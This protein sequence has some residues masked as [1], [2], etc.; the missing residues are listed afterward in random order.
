[1]HS[2]PTGWRE[3]VGQIV[4][5][6]DAMSGTLATVSSE[7]IASLLRDGSLAVT[8]GQLVVQIRCRLPEVA[9][10][11]H[12]AYAF[13]PYC[14]EPEFADFHVELRVPRNLRRWYRPQV[15]FLVDG[16]SPFQPLP[17]D[18]APALLEWG[19]NWS[20][21]ASCHQWLMIHAASLER[22]GR[23]VIL[24]APPGSGKSTLAAALALRGWRL[25]SDE[26]T[27]I[28][29]A[30]L[31]LSALARPINLKNASIPLMRAF[32]PEARWGPVTYD[33]AKGQ[34]THMC[35]TAQ[36]VARMAEGAEPRWIVFPKYS[37]G[38]EPLLAPRSR[39]STF[40]HLAV[41]AFNYSVLGELGFET[42]C[43]L[44]DCCE[45]Y[46]FTYSRL[47]DAL[48]VFEWLASGSPA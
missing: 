27:L 6:A 47:E 18:Q 24:P 40:S 21:A 35:P 13:H 15:E 28:D 48:A 11:L 26:L 34:V 44:I 19:L 41:N 23:A 3:V 36:T 17:R 1:M 2:S 14:P 5:G 37:A 8:T 7:E 38:A 22:G 29:P 39:T 9:E 25:M 31:Q 20:I 10:Y 46:D 32:A 45:C 12:R 4:A 16:E 42:S 43:R 30:S 33:T